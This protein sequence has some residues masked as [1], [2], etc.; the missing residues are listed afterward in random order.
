VEDFRIDFEDGYG[1]RPDDEEDGHARSTARQVA[2]GMGAGTLPPFI[3]IRI[4]SLSSELHRRALR[5]VDFFVTTLV[6]DTGRLPDGFTVTVPKIQDETQ[7]AVVAEALSELER[8]LDIDRIPIEVMV[9]TP[10]MIVDVDGTAGVRKWVEAAQ[11]RVRGAHF[12]TYDYTAALNITAAYQAMDH[13]A[14]DFARHAQQVSL[15]GTGVWISDG[16][17]NVMPI[18]DDREVVRGAMRL[19]HDHIRHSLSHAFYQGWDLH[20]AQLVTRYAAVFSFFLEGLD[21]AGARLSNFIE[22]A[23]KATLVGEVFDDAAT[24]QG[25]LNYFLRAINCGAITEEEATSRTGLTV[26]ELRTRSFLRIL[27]G[28]RRH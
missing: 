23:A 5:T 2:E 3:G 11:G 21:R 10:Q 7:V 12:G 22:S 20:P 17:T 26:N 18:G 1:H 24:G 14:C 15:A 25:L 28:R 6:E 16:A 4:K 27:E 13:P 9:E 8:K 19:H